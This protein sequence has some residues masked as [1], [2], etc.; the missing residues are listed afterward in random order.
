MTW[1][2][3]ATLALALMIQGCGVGDEPWAEADQAI[4][5]VPQIANVTRRPGTVGYADPEHLLDTAEGWGPQTLLLSVSRTVRAQVTMV[6]TPS[7]QMS[8]DK[9]T[10]TLQQALGFSLSDEVEVAA[11]SSTDVTEGWY[12]R[13]EA[14]PTFQAITWDLML[15]GLAGAQRVASGTVYRPVGVFFRTVIL[16]HGRGYQG[17]EDDHPQPGSITA[18][19]NPA[20]GVEAT[21]PH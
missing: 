18:I 12:E 5:G 2:L 16:V 9:I 20:L 11:T 4:W 8:K 15:D 17:I 14:Y 6:Q 1:S 3:G 19:G 21:T 7:V 10:R 13:M